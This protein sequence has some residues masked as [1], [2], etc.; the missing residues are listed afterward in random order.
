[1]IAGRH[2]RTIVS[3]IHHGDLPA[4]RMPGAKGPYLIKKKDLLETIKSKTTPVPYNPKEDH[5][6]T[7]GNH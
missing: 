4:M 2:P 5:D 3:W 1:M 6:P 7:G